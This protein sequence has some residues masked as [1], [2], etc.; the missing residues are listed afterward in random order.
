[1]IQLLSVFNAAKACVVTVLHVLQS[2]LTTQL[3]NNAT[4]VYV[5]IHVRRIVCVDN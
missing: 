1:M 4:V 5:L 2:P 3:L